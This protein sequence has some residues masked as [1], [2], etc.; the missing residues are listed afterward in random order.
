MTEKT[1]VEAMIMGGKPI[2][3]DGITISIVRGFDI[4]KRKMVIRFIF[5]GGIHITLDDVF[6][7]DELLKLAE[8][9]DGVWARR[10]INLTKEFKDDNI[11][12]EV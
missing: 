4:L 1:E 3:L 10:P 12:K 7:H 2:T 9:A 11:Y 8:R 5:P 6:T